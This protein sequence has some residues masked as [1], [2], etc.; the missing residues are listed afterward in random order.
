MNPNFGMS[1]A[2]DYLH[3]NLSFLAQAVTEI[4]MLKVLKV[5]NLTPNFIGGFA[6][7]ALK[8]GAQ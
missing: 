2:K 4:M 1:F 8:N 5:K 7:C 3:K 6:P